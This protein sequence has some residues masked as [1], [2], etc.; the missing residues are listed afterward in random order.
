MA[1]DRAVVDNIRDVCGAV[2]KENRSKNRPLC[3]STEN[4]HWGRPAV[5]NNSSLSSDWKAREEPAENSNMYANGMF[6]ALNKN[7]IVAVSK[8]INEQTRFPGQES[9]EGHS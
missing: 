6:G 2:H 7:V 5:V 8:Q 9:V 3:D 4:G 1:K